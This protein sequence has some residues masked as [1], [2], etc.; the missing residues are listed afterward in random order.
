ME[1]QLQ[2]RRKTRT[3]RTKL[4]SRKTGRESLKSSWM[5]NRR[6][7]HPRRTERTE[8][9]RRK[10]PT[11]ME[12]STNGNKSQHRRRNRKFHFIRTQKINQQRNNYAPRDPHGLRSYISLETTLTSSTVKNQ[13][14][15][16]RAQAHV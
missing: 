9:R 2:P 12:R 10:Q 3:L 4:S 16:I 8:N 13:R 14:L 1:N 11:R 15:K 6:S 7:R 5:Q